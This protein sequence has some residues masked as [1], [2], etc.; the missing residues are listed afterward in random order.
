LGDDAGSPFIWGPIGALHEAV[1]SGE[2]P[3]DRIFQKP[4][5]AYL[6]EHPGDAANF[7]AAMSAGSRSS[8]T[9]VT[10]VYDFTPFA[11]IVDVTRR[12]IAGLKSPA[13]Q[14]AR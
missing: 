4:F 8:G 11:R 7:N 13:A 6:G 12:W 10:Q 5:F 2:P 14:A 3:A 1:S 9:S